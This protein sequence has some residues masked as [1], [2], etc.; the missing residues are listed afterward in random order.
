MSLTSEI[1][2]NSFVKF[3]SANNNKHDCDMSVLDYARRIV[4]LR[5]A[6]ILNVKQN[7]INQSMKYVLSVVLN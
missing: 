1:T 5:E 4:L 7:K 6:V 3:D 2:R